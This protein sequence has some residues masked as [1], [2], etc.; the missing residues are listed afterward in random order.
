MLYAVQL[1]RLSDQEPLAKG[2]HRNVYAYPDQPG[3]LIKV[4][5]PRTR[6]NRSVSKRLVRRILPDTAFRNALKEIECEMK[7][8]LKSGD[9][10]AQLPLA[11]SF[12]VVQTDVGPGVVV[13][14]IQSGD[15]Q[16]AKHLLSTCR[17]HELSDQML[18]DLNR[19]VE[20]LFDL[21][22][23]GRD[24][25]AENIVY[26]LRDQTRMFFLIDGYGERNLV[27]LRSLSRRLNDRSLNKQMQHIADRTGLRWEKTQRVFSFA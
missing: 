3:L 4:T 10:I 13:E 21:Q 11:R 1:L 16:L 14:R 22:I 24:I 25:H 8:A 17:Q 27:P 19:F 15:G 7:A 2:G 20:K 12:G 5:R 18:G 6:R 23:V 9:K 26:G